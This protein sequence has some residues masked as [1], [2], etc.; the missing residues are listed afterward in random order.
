M[1]ELLGLK[2][3]D[4]F[5]CEL[6][7]AVEAVGRSE[8]AGIAERERMFPHV[9]AHPE[10]NEWLMVCEACFAKHSPERN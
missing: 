1:S 10:D 7:G 3:E 6:C 4:T 9:D 2:P 8:E 5:V